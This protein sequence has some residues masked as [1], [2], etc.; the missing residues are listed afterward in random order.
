MT[1]D[2]TEVPSIIIYVGG[3]TAPRIVKYGIGTESM[4]KLMSE[5]HIHYISQSSTVI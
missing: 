4:S 1:G 2:V 3:G 5:T